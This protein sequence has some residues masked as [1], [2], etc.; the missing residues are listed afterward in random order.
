MLRNKKSEDEEDKVEAKNAL[1]KY[2]YNM[3]NTIK[4]EK[5]ASKLD[6]ADKKIEDAVD[7]DIQWQR[8]WPEET[9]EAAVQP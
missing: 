5:I 6:S 1:E 7:C 2:A 9:D 4:D 8:T 3:C